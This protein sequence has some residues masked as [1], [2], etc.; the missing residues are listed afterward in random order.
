MT[1]THKDDG[2][3][4]LDRSPK[5]FDTILNFLRDG[6][7]PTIA[8]QVSKNEILAEA[9][10]YQVQLC[11]SPLLITPTVPVVRCGVR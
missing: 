9:N 1:T 11:S 10:F 4:F 7:L 8:E 2:A 5:H 6:S 3:Y